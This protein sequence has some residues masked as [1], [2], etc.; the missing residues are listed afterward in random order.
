MLCLLMTCIAQILFSVCVIFCS[1]GHGL[2]CREVGST[3]P[4]IFICERSFF[5]FFTNPTAAISF[6]FRNTYN[7]SFVIL[8]WDVMC[9]FKW[10]MCQWRSY[11]CA[12]QLGHSCFLHPHILFILIWALCNIQHNAQLFKMELF[13]CTRHTFF[14]FGLPCR[15]PF[16]LY[17]G[18]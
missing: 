9:I 15:D 2:R 13:W 8:K 12:Q 14:L 10:E 16:F 18:I 4:A 1:W 7:I 3:L 17:W 5:K 11:L 6:S